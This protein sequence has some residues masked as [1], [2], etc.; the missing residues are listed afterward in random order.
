M[1]SDYLID[2]LLESTLES[3]NIANRLLELPLLE[4]NKRSHSE[5]WSALECLEHLNLYNEFY[6]PEI[7]NRMKEK[8]HLKATEIFI[9]GWLGNYFANTMKV[10]NGKFKKMK[11]FKDKN[12]LGSELNYDVI[13]QY[14]K[15]QLQMVEHLNNSRNINL[16]K[17]KTNITISK[18]I[19]LKL[20]DTFRFLTYHN[21]R[22]IIQALKAVE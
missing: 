21:E 19:K 18:L 16:N 9:P 7:N 2:S 6:L 8:R 15:N 1:E 20:G 11:T 4:L 17:V 10:N 5:S 14:L 22:H 3:N 13:H 12:P